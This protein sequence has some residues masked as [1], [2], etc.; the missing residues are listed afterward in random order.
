MGSPGAYVQQMHAMYVFL[1]DQLVRAMIDHVYVAPA[2]LQDLAEIV[3]L[4]RT[5]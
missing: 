4:L 5:K 3:A 2:K 1:F